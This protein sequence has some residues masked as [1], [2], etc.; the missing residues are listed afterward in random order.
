MQNSTSSTFP[1]LPPTILWVARILAIAIFGVWGFFIVAHLLG[2]AGT[3]SRALTPNDFASLSAM[4]ASLL[5]LGLSFKW[6]RLGA[7]FTLVAVATGAV[8]N[9]KVLVFPG[10]LIPIVAALFL[11]HSYFR[12]T[13]CR[14]PAGASGN[15]SVRAG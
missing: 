9:W 8:M 12:N 6:E 2:D 14:A 4:V 3:S 15:P 1:A 10:T 7:T 5:G 11:W 13:G